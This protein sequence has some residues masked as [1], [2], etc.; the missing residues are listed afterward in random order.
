MPIARQ[1]PRAALWFSVH[2]EADAVVVPVHGDVDLA[3]SARL[4][5]VLADL[6]EGQGNHDVVVDLE[7]VTAIDPAAF[8][9]LAVAAKVAGLHGGNLAVRGAGRL[10]GVDADTDTA[11][12]NTAAADGD[13][14]DTAGRVGPTCRHVVEFHEN[15][16]LL[17]E[18]VRDYLAPA[19]RGDDAAVVVATP[20]HRALFAEALEGA[21]VDT[22]AAREAGRYIEV[23]T[24]E[25]LAALMVDGRPSRER[26]E[27]AIGGLLAAAGAGG[28]AVR[29]YGE[30]VAVLWLEGSPAAALA[31]EDLWTDL[32]HD[33]DF[34][35]LCA[36]PACAFDDSGAA[37]TLGRICGQHAGH[38]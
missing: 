3:A 29:I 1:R 2:R 31:L 12:T 8:G 35:L 18:S 22:V 26:F 36:Y 23:D 9:V 33:H 14:G 19:L 25:M 5:A 30:A 27:H 24:H 4:G 21:G 7:H 20:N 38:L 16:R 28:R 34:S 10:A 6:I 17:A 37:G 32:G 11:D 13:T 15:D